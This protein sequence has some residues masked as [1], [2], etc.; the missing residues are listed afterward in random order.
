MS[1]AKH[2]RAA[3]RVMALFKDY[4]AKGRPHIVLKSAEVGMTPDSI[5][6]TIYNGFNWILD[7][8]KDDLT[9]YNFWASLKNSIKVT[10]TAD[11]VLIR[12]RGIDF[13][14]PP[15]ESFQKRA[16]FRS[17]FL[18][19][20]QGNLKNS[21]DVWPRQAP[22]VPLNDSDFTFFESMITMYQNRYIFGEVDRVNGTVHF[23]YQPMRKLYDTSTK[24]IQGPDLSD[25]AGDSGP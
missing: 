23:I 4:E 12:G 8:C 24:T 1:N 9:T 25:P 2:V 19:W 13:T 16:A 18:S 5:R 3:E 15:D 21:G 17:D 11:G 6:V 20:A 10:K 14:P 22:G 7:K